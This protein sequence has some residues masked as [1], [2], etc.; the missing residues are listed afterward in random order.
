MATPTF[1]ITRLP[2]TETP[3]WFGRCRLPGGGRLGSKLL[4]ILSRVAAWPG[5]LCLS[6]CYCGLPLSGAFVLLGLES[7]AEGAPFTFA[8]TGSMATERDSYSA[9]LLSNGKVLVAGGENGTTGTLGSA[10]LYDLTAGTWS[11]T[12]NLA[13][14][15]YSQSA[16]LLTNG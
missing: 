1:S 6:L 14:A 10:E 2:K 8:S 12:G 15:R 4:R 9:T 16:T 3:G 11:A 7:V 5:R 13:T